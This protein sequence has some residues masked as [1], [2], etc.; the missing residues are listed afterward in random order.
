MSTAFRNK[1]IKYAL[2]NR[3]RAIWKKRLYALM[4]GCNSLSRLARIK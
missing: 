2:R 3:H 4:Y 1:L